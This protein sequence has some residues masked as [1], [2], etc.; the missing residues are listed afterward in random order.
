MKAIKF[1]LVGAGFVCFLAL[2]P[3]RASARIH[4]RISFGTPVVHRHSGFQSG[5]YPRDRWHSEYYR[6]LDRDR[7]MWLDKGRYRHPHVFRP[8]HFYRRRP[9]CL[10]GV[11]TWTENC[12]P[13]VVGPPV[14]VEVPKVITERQVVVKTPEYNYKLKYD[15]NTAK[16][17]EKLRRK[18]SELLK[19]LEI[20]NKEKRIEA[21]RELAGFSFDDKVGK[22][23]EDVLLSD[24]DPELRKKV[25]NSL[26]KTTNRNVLAALEKAKTEDSNKE[27]RQEAYKAII[28]I[29]EY[30]L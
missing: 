18:K 16:L 5:C 24:P 25:A 30:R 14:V 26:G 3:S 7:Y 23:L 21:I 9:L 28:K 13:I 22:A 17:F 6:W 20:G 4:F 1:G 19:T 2:L 10:S 11:S 15:E 8:R 12:C 29:R 27:V